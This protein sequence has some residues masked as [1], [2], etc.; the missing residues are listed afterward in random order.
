MVIYQISN[1]EL[2]VESSV[3]TVAHGGYSVSVRCL[4]TGKLL[5]SFKVIQ[6]KRLAV[7]YAHKCVEVQE[8]D[9]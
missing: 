4:D 9:K 8:C 2:M 5:P 3:S 7:E 1:F 6:S